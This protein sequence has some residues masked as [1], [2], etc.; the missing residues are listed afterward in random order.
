MEQRLIHTHFVSRLFRRFI[1]GL[2]LLSLLA[3]Y[4]NENWMKRR[5]KIDSHSSTN[6]SAADDRSEGGQSTANLQKTAQGL[7]L[8]CHIVQ[9]YQWPFCELVV[10]IGDNEKGLNLHQFE[11]I[12]LQLRSSG[13]EASHPVRI[14]L[15]NFHPAYSKR[16]ATSTLK[17]HEVVFDP[18]QN[19]QIVELKL[20]QFMVAS[21]WSQ[22]HPTNLEY[23]GPQLD[24][25]VAI[26]FA[27]GGNV[28]PGEHKITLESAE[29]VGQ[30]ISTEKFRL[31]IIFIWLL[32]I[33]IY[34]IWEWSLS[35]QAL[36]E[37]E[38]LKAELERSNHALESR[39]EERTRAL[40]AS[41]SRL[42]ETL[43]NL[44]GTRHELVQNEKN[45]ALGALVSG[46][47]HE[48]NTPIGNALLVCST[49]SDK[50]KELEI[51]SETKF[52]RKALKDFF[53]ESYHGTAILQQNLER[54]A[55]LISSFKQLSADQHSEQRRQFHLLDVAHETQLAM[56]PSIRQTPHVFNIDIDPDIVMDAYP[57][58][59]SQIF[60]NFINNALL[61][62][63]DN[64]AQGH[65]LL[66]AK[67]RDEDT[68]EII[69]SDDGTGIPA[70]ILRR[71]FEP[72][73]TTKLGKGGSGLGMHL[74]HT[75]ITQIFGGKIEIHSL[76]GEGTSIH[77]LVPLVAPD[78][79]KRTL[80]IGVPK[81]VLEDYLQ[82]L[83][84]RKILEIADYSGEYSRRDV[85]E[86]AFFIRALSSV[87]PDV[88]YEL[89][90]VDSY[91]NGIEQLRASIISALAT[92]CWESDL[93]AY[94][95]EICVS[96]AMIA[97]G[98]SIV[99]IYTSPQN[100]HARACQSLDDF[101]QLRV[102]SNRD[103]SADWNTLEQLGVRHCLDVKTWRQMV[104]MVSS[105]EVD[106]LLAPFSTHRDMKI[107]LDD[108]QLI[109]VKGLQIAL[110]GSRHFASSKTVQGLAIA[111]MIFPEL[112]RYLEDGSFDLALHQ[113]GFYNTLTKEWR[114]L[115]QH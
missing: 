51:I 42:I 35:R 99:G 80:K 52:T 71:V 37:S 95:E 32:V 11:S 64:I 30:W 108:C 15:R 33:F 106:A 12:R 84:D 17:P 94:A 41:N 60:I 7:E 43:Q 27:T 47:A 66:S 29:F 2:I 34:L 73:F 44:E 96:E 38:H 105:G 55:D 23:L 57:G 36:L 88:Q 49:L 100:Q 26:S 86:L 70:T 67:K 5:F 48:L 113:C 63:F 89:S 111:E 87:W 74:A 107:E 101:Q 91:A 110:T 8:S 54:A 81:D 19:T 56:L 46:V 53:N 98:H 104:Y 9:A 1:L 21:W 79:S 102:V 22:E 78:I 24:N 76:P 4:A 40:A 25:V 28:L 3:L 112:N 39:V 65:M 59:L 72:F 10:E 50:I 114:I 75:V 58:P 92:S 68:I 115:N 6:I 14:F 85:V 16:S 20:N 69:F 109:P 61:H 90:P 13:P 97:D 83:G 45:A 103:W 93:L 77:M 62:A 82:F 18:N 31:G